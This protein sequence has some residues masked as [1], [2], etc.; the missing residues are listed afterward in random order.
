VS[1]AE[2]FESIEGEE[3]YRRLALGKPML[4]LDVRTPTEFE[5]RYIPGS[6][7]IPLHEL[8]SRV[9]EVPNSGMPIAVVCEHGLRSVSACRLLAEH[10]M[11]PLFNLEGGLSAW[12]GPFAGRVLNGQPRHGI[13]PSS[14][15]VESFDLLP[16]GLALDLTMGHG[17]NA[18]YLATRGYDVDGVDKNPRAVERARAAA[19]R[20]GA[21]I[22]A[23]VGDVEDGSYIVPIETYDL[24]VSFNYLHRPLFKDIREG[25]VPGGGV[26]Y[27]TYTVD[28]T[29]FGHPEDRERLLEPGELKQAFEDWEVLR[30]REVIG[31]SRENG[32]PR[33][34]AGIIARK[35]R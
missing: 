20:L 28:Q 1:S 25:V 33:A 26:I 2:R 5:E 23:I 22:R 30:Y 35:P 11:G 19:R 15:L 21:P 27:Q 17:R 12:P 16:R 10:G 18:I 9:R 31:A 14:F 6:V 13:A 34:V 3:L 4:V 24:I 8:E 32:E 29:R 7:L